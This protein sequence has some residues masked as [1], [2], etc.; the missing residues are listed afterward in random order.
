MASGL[1]CSLGCECANQTQ[2]RIQSF[3][4]LGRCTGHLIA[5]YM[6]PLDSLNMTSS[7]NCGDKA[8]L[9]TKYINPI[10]FELVLVPPVM[11]APSVSL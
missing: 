11:W 5:S 1:G 3:M 6:G 7:A 4:W 9:V 2:G 10:I 8:F